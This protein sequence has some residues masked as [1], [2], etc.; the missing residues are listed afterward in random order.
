[1]ANNKATSHLLR[2]VDN[3]SS[4]TIHMGNEE[5][6][7]S[8]QSSETLAKEKPSGWMN[9]LEVITWINKIILYRI[10]ILGYL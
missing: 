3:T 10:S 9:I 1:M 7:H 4:A 2:K 8:E 5:M 6:R